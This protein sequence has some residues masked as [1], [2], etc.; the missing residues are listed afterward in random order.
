MIENDADGK[1]KVY[2]K[3][4]IKIGRYQDK[5]LPYKLDI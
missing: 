2:D 1:P 4:H 5:E 3:K